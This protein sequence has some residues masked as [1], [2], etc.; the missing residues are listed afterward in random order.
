MRR[1]WLA[2]IMGF[3]L[4]TALGV[5][6]G[7]QASTGSAQAASISPS[8][9]FAS[10]HLAGGGIFWALVNVTDTYLY[11]NLTQETYSELFCQARVAAGSSTVQIY[12][13]T[14]ATPGEC[15]ALNASNNH[16]Y[17]HNPNGCNGTSDTYL[18]WKF[19]YLST[20]GG[21]KTYMLQSQYAPSG[22]PCVVNNRADPATFQ[23]CSSSNS[24]EQL[25]YGPE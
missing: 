6:V 13:E 3:T 25:V 9:C 24:A 20:V 22:Y 19:V 12:D 11:F 23:A 15:L 8:N 17:L 10:F 16:V 14:V 7:A 18:Q 5:P 21:V 2:L 4:I 1:K